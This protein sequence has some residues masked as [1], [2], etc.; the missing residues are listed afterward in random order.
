MVVNKLA[1]YSQLWTIDCDSF[2]HTLRNN[3]IAAKNPAI[4]VMLH[5]ITDIPLLRIDTATSLFTPLK[6]ITLW[7]IFESSM[8]TRRCKNRSAPPVA[9]P[10][11]T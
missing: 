9:N 10:V 4:D 2:W 11:M 6:E 1:L 7:R 5:S 8:L 3:L